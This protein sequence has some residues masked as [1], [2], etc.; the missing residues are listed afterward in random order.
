MLGSLAARSSIT[1]SRIGLP[2]SLASFTRRL[3]PAML[4]TP[5]AAMS[6]WRRSISATHQRSALA[7]C[8]MSVTTGASR[9]GMPSYTES[10]SIF[11]SIMMR[12]TCSAV[13]L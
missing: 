2:T 10:S 8:F 6:W 7:A 1:G 3:K 9:C 12:R 4:R 11:G 5:S 13:D